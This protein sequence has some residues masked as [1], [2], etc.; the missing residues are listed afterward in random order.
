MQQ[1]FLLAA[2]LLGGSSHETMGNLVIAG[3]GPTI[4]EITERALALAGGKK[5]HVLIIPQASTRADTGQ[6]SEEMWRKAGATHV[7]VLDFKDK[8]AALAAI[9]DAT[10]I[11][12]PGGSQSLLMKILSQNGMVGP[13]RDRFQHGATIGGTSAGAAVMSV[14]MLNGEARL[15]RVVTSTSKDAEGLGLWP[16]VIIDQH[17]IRRYRFNRLFS[18]VVNHPK[19]VGIGID[20]STAIVVRGRSFEVIGKSG[21]YVIDGRK[22]SK[23]ATK[24]GEPAAASNVALHLLNAGMRFDLD[25]GV[26]LPENSKER[27]DRLTRADANPIKTKP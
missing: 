11:W 14:I 26:L 8:K 20:E 7:T 21:V 23:I 16:D 5:A 25:K 2:A 18:A 24:N 15:D 6:R 12:M 10:L 13:I 27:V 4:P 17:H 19:F 3:G 9:K 22:M 1:L